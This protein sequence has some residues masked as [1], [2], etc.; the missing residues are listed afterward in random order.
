[1]LSRDVLQRLHFKRFTQVMEATTSKPESPNPDGG[2]AKL[3]ADTKEFQ[4]MINHKDD[5]LGPE[6]GL[7][8]KPIFNKEKFKRRMPRLRKGAVVRGIKVNAPFRDMH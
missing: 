2:Q 4:D 7:G 3:L 6:A 1:M 8:G 5:N